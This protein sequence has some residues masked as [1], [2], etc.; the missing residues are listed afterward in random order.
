[1]SHREREGVW[2]QKFLNKLLSEQAMG[3][4]EMLG[5]N[6]TSLTLTKDLESQN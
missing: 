1:M 6:E 4:I 3:K 2:V 5:D